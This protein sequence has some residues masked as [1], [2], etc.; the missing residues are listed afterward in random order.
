MSTPWF[1]ANPR[2]FRQECD[3][4]GR[5]YP[6]MK[7]DTATLAAGKVVFAG[8]LSIGIGPKM[9]SFLVSLEYPVGFP[10]VRPDVIPLREPTSEDGSKS[11]RFFS[12]RHQMANGSICLFEHDPAADPRAHVSGVS[13]L[14]RARIW[15]PHALRQPL[16]RELDTLE[17]ELEAH[18]HRVGDVFVGPMMFQDLGPS[19]ELLLDF[20][21]APLRDEQYPFHMVTHIESDGV[22]HDDRDT[23]SRIGVERDWDSAPTARLGPPRV[24][25]FSL[26]REPPPIRTSDELAQLLFPHD[27]DP[28]ARFKRE[29]ASNLANRIALDVPL[30]FPGRRAGEFEWLF[31][32]FRIREKSLPV[33]RVPGIREPGLVLDF[34]GGAA[35]DDAPPAVLHIQD[36]RPASLLVRNAGRIPMIASSLKVGLGGAGSL[37]STVADLLAKAGVGDLRIV[38]PALLNA[39]NAVR[40]L[41]AVTAAGLHKAAVVAAMVS[42]HNPHC[43]SSCD[44]TRGV[45]E[46]P[47]DDPFWSKDF[48]VSTIADDATELAFNRLAVERGLT[49]YYLRALRSGTA[50]RLVRVRPHE[51]ACFECIGHYH[52]DGDARAVVI[53]PQ[54]DEIITRECGQ[55]VLA[56]S[57]ADLAI[58]AGLGVRQILSDSAARTDNNQ[59]VWASEGIPEHPTLGSAF[60]S[61]AV[62]LSPHPRC[63]VCATGA[64][65]RVKI[66]EDLK[67]TMLGLARRHAPNET[68]GILVGR[69][70]DDAVTVLAVSDAGTNAVSEPTRFERDGAHSQA[71]LEQTVA[72]L[73]PGVDYVGEWHS[74]PDGD[75]SP[76]P[77]DTQSFIEIAADPNYLTTAPVLVIVAPDASGQGARW[78][79]SVFPVDGLARVVAFESDESAPGIGAAGDVA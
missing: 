43:K 18:Y 37:G 47:G 35:L 34:A 64:P 6:E 15:I 12:A 49:V 11:P 26:D 68:G 62:A 46:L 77:R 66:A 59:W 20:F 55:P 27:A 69:R 42:A 32:R 61:A 1:V 25:W 22:W 52:A 76:S 23:L 5:D 78:S 28:V 40:H 10:Y 7:L 56:S 30:R 13:A 44:F 16:P 54:P 31:L 29:V 41:A 57:A 33:A 72:E 48:V 21:K 19:G 70:T 45:L 50:G 65:R 74:H 2:L 67:C 36:L 79:A 14:R 38:D 73:G 24:K 58:V 60:S 9:E 63:G 75:P 8:A 39:H 3:E 17:S 51:D 4:L 53:P 71:F